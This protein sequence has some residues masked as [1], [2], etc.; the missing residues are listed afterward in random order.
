MWWRLGG[1][2]VGRDSPKSGL[3]RWHE[4]RVIGGMVEG[5]F[6]FVLGSRC[7]ACH[8]GSASEIGVLCFAV[9]AIE[10][11]VL[12]WRTRTLGRRGMPRPF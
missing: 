10:D 7:C 9:A 4:R 12:A 2:K 8:Y 1:R 3:G 6:S 11:L 5:G